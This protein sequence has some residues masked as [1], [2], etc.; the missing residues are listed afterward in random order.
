MPY[1]D[2]EEAG[3]RNR[4]WIFAEY[5]T[6]PLGV[7]TK[8]PG[9]GIEVDKAARYEIPNRGLNRVDQRY[10]LDPVELQARRSAR[11][12]AEL[13]D[14]LCIRENGGRVEV[15]SKSEN[16]YSVSGPDQDDDCKCPDFFRLRESYPAEPLVCKHILIARL[17]EAAR[18]P[19]FL[20]VG[21]L[22]IAEQLGVAY[23]TVQ[24]ACRKGVCIATK[25]KRTWVV[26]SDDAD[27]FITAYRANMYDPDFMAQFQATVKV[28]MSNPSGKRPGG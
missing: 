28:L 5:E 1:T 26:T 11:A 3:G 4:E 25:I 7:R 8:V 9:T 20:D 21:V 13:G 10:A 27:A 17:A 15:V 14:S 18:D 19:F 6:D 22:W 2:E 16:R 24:Q 12:V 23:Q